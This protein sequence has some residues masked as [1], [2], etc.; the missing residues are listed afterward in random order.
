MILEHGSFMIVPNYRRR[1]CPLCST[2]DSEC[3]LAIDVGDILNANWSY[4]KEFWDDLEKADHKTLSINK[5]VNC[6]FIF[7][8]MLPS[9]EFLSF[10]YD[11]LI[12]INLARSESYC[13]GNLAS[14]MKYLSMLLNLVD[15]PCKILDYGCGFGPTL[16]LLKKII[17]VVSI[18]YETSHAR[19]R[20]LRSSGY[21]IVDN[22]NDLL[23]FSPFHVVILDNVLEHVPEPHA[24]L[25]Q[26]KKICTE[27]ALL[28]I[29]V[30][31]ANQAYIRRQKVNKR[32]G[33]LIA[34]DVNPWEHLSYFSLRHLDNLLSQHGFRPL[35]SSEYGKEVEIGLRSEG[36]KISRLNNSIA[37][38]GRMVK[39]VVTGN[40]SQNI[41]MRFYRKINSRS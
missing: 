19:V 34:M 17:G 21:T 37:S 15:S 14:R 18:G 35:K 25:S 4:R 1:V 28:Y 39:Y 12:D 3:L 40:G 16:A 6:D 27:N 2:V 22:E 11:Q 24:V 36:R 5:C 29:S 26:I 20:E 7:S 32:Q 10:V 41:N 8:A 33:K 30:P 23:N 9:D 38:M 13:A 31:S